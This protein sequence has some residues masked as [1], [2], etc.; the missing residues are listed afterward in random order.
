MSK[1]FP[2]LRYFSIASLLVIVTVA[3]V[4]SLVFRQATSNKMIQY[5]EKNNILL[6]RVLSNTIWPQW[7]S[8]IATADNL[9]T[10]ELISHPGFKQFENLI[11]ASISNI[12]VLKIKIFN[13]AGDVRFSTEVAQVGDKKSTYDGVV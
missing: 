11:K 4:L 1:Q 5:G 7:E 10:E 8:F 6:T 3:I 12:S 13:L 2:L 9:S